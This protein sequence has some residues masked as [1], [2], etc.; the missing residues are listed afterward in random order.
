MMTHLNESFG[1]VHALEQV[2]IFYPFDNLKY[3]HRHDE[4][5][6][7]RGND[8][9]VSYYKAYVYSYQLSLLVKNTDWSLEYKECWWYIVIEANRTIGGI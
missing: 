2:H 9:F 1:V 4:N 3:Y 8:V 7:N 5:L 6:S